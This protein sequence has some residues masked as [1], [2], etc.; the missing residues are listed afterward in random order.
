MNI[1]SLAIEYE[2]HEFAKELWPINP[3][4]T[5]KGVREAHKLI[6]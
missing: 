2:I 6:K 1:K 5:D 3:N 4:I